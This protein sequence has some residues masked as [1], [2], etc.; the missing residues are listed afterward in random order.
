MELSTDIAL[1]RLS[2]QQRELDVTA[3][4]LANSSTP[5]FK[6]SRV[7]FN[8]W[9][10]DQVGTNAPQG[11]RTVAYTQDRATYR[12]LQVGTIQHTANPLDL[13]I[14]GNG[15]FTVATPRGPRLTRSGHFSLQADGTIGDLAGDKLLDAAGQPLRLAPTDTSITVTA[16]GTLSTES[17]TIGRIGVVQPSDPNRMTAEGSLDLRADT[18]TAPLAQPQIVQGAVENSNVQPIVETTRMMDEVRSFQFTTQFIQ[19]ESD[20]MQ[21]AIDKMTQSKD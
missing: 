19:A 20:R 4:N 2:A 9:L 5:G 13:A 10:S 18:P 11:E 14:A 17:G 1:S 15:F 8:D 7:L 21:N 16:D 3:A 6:S 12:E